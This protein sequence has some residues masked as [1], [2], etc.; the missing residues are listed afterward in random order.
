MN[1]KII[2]AVAILLIVAVVFVACKGKGDVE[3]PTESTTKSTTESK[4][5]PTTVDLEIY[6]M[7]GDGVGTGIIPGVIEEGDM[8]GDDIIHVGG[9]S[10]GQDGEDSISWEEVVGKNS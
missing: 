8:S 2:L 10:N 5:E 3:E 4:T 9:D 1:K 7:S 6:D